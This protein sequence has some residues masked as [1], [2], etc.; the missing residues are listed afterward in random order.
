MVPLV[1]LSAAL[2]V[3][4]PATPISS[5]WLA[6]LIAIAFAVTAVTSI[7]SV[8]AAL[9][10]IARVRPVE[11]DPLRSS[12]PPPCAV[13]VL[14]V[15]PAMV[16][17][18]PPV[19]LIALLA[20]LPDIVTVFAPTGERGVRRAQRQRVEV[21]R[22]DVEGDGV[23]TG[24]RRER[25]V[26]TVGRKRPARPVRRVRPVAAEDAPARLPGFNRHG[27]SRPSSRLETAQSK[28]RAVQLPLEH[29]D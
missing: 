13:T 25:D 21:R 20:A 18:P 16:I 6:L 5:V 26:I 9:A 24:Q 12:V 19:R 15:P 22:V 27:L 28:R 23:G 14:A 3:R 17:L 11:T 29:P 8:L 10:S 7:L 2:M 1:M 4:L